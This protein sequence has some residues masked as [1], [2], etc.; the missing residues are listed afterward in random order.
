MKDVQRFFQK[1]HYNRYKIYNLCAERTY[2]AAKFEGMVV[3]YPFV[4]HEPCPFLKLLLF[5]EDVHRWLSE[6]PQNVAA[7]HCIEGKGMQSLSVHRLQCS[8]SA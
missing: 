6:H 2:D 3:R 4:D 1:R 8:S 5:C 7:V